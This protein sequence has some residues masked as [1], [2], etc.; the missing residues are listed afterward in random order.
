MRWIESHE[1][2]PCAA[3]ACQSNAAPRAAGCWHNDWMMTA[4][5]RK[6]SAIRRHAAGDLAARRSRGVGRAGALVS[7]AGRPT[8]RRHCRCC[9]AH[10]ALG[11]LIALWQGRAGLALLSFA[12]AFAIMLIWWHRIAPTNE[13]LWADDV[14]QITNGTIDGNRVT[15]R[16]VRNFDWRSN[17]DYTQRWE[18]RELRSRQAQFSRYDH[19]VL[20]WLGDRAHVDIV[21]LR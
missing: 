15:L 10:S 9:G 6:C 21:R 14:A 16:N 7:G 5:Y 1:T 13:R 12:L 3:G 17:S 8:Q 20:G 2:V 4:S 19:V 11:V 18:T